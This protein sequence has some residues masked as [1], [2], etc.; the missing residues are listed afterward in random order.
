MAAQRIEIIQ[1]FPFSVEK[2]FAFLSDHENLGVI[3]P[4]KI[5]RIRDGQ[6]SVNVSAQP[7]VWQRPA[8]SCR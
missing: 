6:G 3:F 2:L 4:L 8:V 1:E 5:T 7:V